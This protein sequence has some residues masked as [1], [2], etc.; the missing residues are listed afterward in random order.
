[1][2]LQES[3][4]VV[5]AGW[6][7]ETFSREQWQYPRE[8]NTDLTWGSYKRH[9]SDTHSNSDILRSTRLGRCTHSL[10]DPANVR[11]FC[12][13][14]PVAFTRIT[15]VRSFTFPTV[16]LR[17][18]AALFAVERSPSILAHSPE[19]RHFVN[20]EQP[21]Q[22]EFG[23]DSRVQKTISQRLLFCFLRIHCSHCCMLRSLHV[24]NVIPM[25][26]Q[27][28]DWWRRCRGIPQH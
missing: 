18:L 24:T 4:R 9:A 8:S 20:V 16:L 11:T 6:A 28:G 26:T 23:C 15:F 25:P 1:M 13:P 10:N 14:S 3:E 17:L 19:A 27:A 12:G 7:Q 2:R 21:G 22:P 5:T